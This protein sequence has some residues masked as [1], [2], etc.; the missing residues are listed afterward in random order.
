MFILPDRPS[1]LLSNS[2]RSSGTL[3]TA[4]NETIRPRQL[5]SRTLDSLDFYNF[6]IGLPTSHLD[7]VIDVDKDY[8]FPLPRLHLSQPEKLGF[9]SVHPREINT[10][11]LAR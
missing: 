8:Y 2:A 10:S 9:D 6:G 5:R 7:I 3:V 11:R 4:K 1:F